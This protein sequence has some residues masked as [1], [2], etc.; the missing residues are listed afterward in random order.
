M[1]E[2]RSRYGIDKLDPFGR[3]LAEAADKHWFTVR[4]WDTY[5]LNDQQLV[6]RVRSDIE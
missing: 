6:E 1:S 3:Q 4:P 2:D 5:G